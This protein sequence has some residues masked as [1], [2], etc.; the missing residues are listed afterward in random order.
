MAVGSRC[1]TAQDHSP[2]TVKPVPESLLRRVASGDSTAVNEVLDRYGGLV[3]SLARR[4]CA[5]PSDA[6]DATQEVFIDLWQSARRFD[7][8]LASEATFVAMIARRRLIDR[9]RRSERRRDTAS[10]VSDVA[11]TGG[12]PSDRAELLDD[13]AR[14]SDAMTSLRPEQQQVLK[15]SIY[16]GLTHDE[17]ARS[18]GLPLGTVKTHARLGLIQIRELVGKPARAEG[19]TA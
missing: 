4:F 17:I 19:G 1:V 6:E 13:V 10:L 3:W 8:S 2:E 12:N 9:F 16:D 18:T 14:I 15:M 11:A 7:E 5:N